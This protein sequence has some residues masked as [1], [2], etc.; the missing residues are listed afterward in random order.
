VG[1]SEET[2]L[3]LPDRGVERMRSPLNE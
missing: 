1:V 2:H 3:R